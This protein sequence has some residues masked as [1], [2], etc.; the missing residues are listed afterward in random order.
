MADS[1]L[2]SIKDKVFRGILAFFLFILVG[3]LMVTFLPGDAERSFF[4][5]VGGR[6]RYS[7]GSIGGSEISIP[8]FQAAK[9]DC[10]FRFK[11]QMPSM[12]ENAEALNSCA[13]DTVRALHIG[14]I[15]A[16]SLGFKV[17]EHSI[18][19]ELSDQARL[20]H[21]EQLSTPG[22]TEADVRKPEAIYA[23]LLHAVP[24]EY[25]VDSETV[26]RLYQD[27]RISQLSKSESEKQLESQASSAKISL[28]LITYS[29]AVLFKK[30]ENEIKIPESDI[31]AKYEEEV[32][33][34]KWKD[35]KAPTFEERKAILRSSLLL[36]VRQKKAAELK[37]KIQ[38]WVKE[39]KNLQFISQQ[40]GIPVFQARNE[41]ISSLWE[42]KTNSGIVRLGESSAFLKD[43]TSGNL[44]PGTLK[45]PYTDSD[46]PVLVEFVGLSVPK[47]PDSIARTS[48][49]ENFTNTLNPL[50]IAFVLE[51]NETI[52]EKY[53]LM[54]TIQPAEGQE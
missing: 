54:R 18:R 34:G 47:T 12:A 35:K 19:Q 40:I 8:I 43:L 5:L 52:G 37:E 2:T 48:G 39:G 38:S 51:I 25:R 23:Q 30:L 45:G 24:L 16:D 6:A 14:K 20:L 21:K 1:D 10:Y 4:D 26:T 15:M 46:Q 41:P 33:S 29:D 42:L 31:K 49:T 36:D 32:S 22:Y 50:L 28:N 3:M 9:R 53:P 11:E 13:Y 27:F 44:K 7:A 17:T